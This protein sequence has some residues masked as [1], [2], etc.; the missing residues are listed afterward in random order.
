MDELKKMLDQTASA[1]E[2]AARAVRM[3]A[4]EVYIAA[5]RLKQKRQAWQQGILFSLCALALAACAALVL[6]DY[7][8][9]GS[10]SGASA[11]IA[12]VL[13]GFAALTLLLSP[14][15]A[16]FAEEEQAHE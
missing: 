4:P 12:L 3:L 1:D 13:A 16:Y 6:G 5:E 10:L 15:L 14:V 8:R 9:H 11:I 2:G 7:R